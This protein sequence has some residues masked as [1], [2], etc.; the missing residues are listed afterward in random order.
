MDFEILFP[1][2]RDHLQYSLANIYTRMYLEI[3]TLQSAALVPPK[4]WP[5][6]Y[7]EK[8]VPKPSMNFSSPTKQETFIAIDNPANRGDH[9]SSKM[10]FCVSMWMALVAL[11]LVLLFWFL[12]RAIYKS[13]VIEAPRR[14][15]GGCK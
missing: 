7:W 11:L 2:S 6:K 4:F 10:A 8:N 13:M 1:H 12:V 9:T 15:E 5:L 3:S 14:G